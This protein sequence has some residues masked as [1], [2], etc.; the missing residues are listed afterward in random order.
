[1][2]ENGDNSVGVLLFLSSEKDVFTDDLVALLAKLAENVS[3]AL[4]NF[5]R[6]DGRVKTE[7]QKERVTRMFAA[8]SSTNEAIM[9]GQDANTAFRNGMRGRRVWRQVHV[10]DHR[11]GASRQ[12]FSTS[13][14]RRDRRRQ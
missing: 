13:L 4:D 2:L 1:L 8:L 11:P 14:R 3:F 6:A 10:D 12:G 5:D 9:R 7:D